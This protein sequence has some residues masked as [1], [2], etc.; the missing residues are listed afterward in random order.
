[1]CES[2]PLGAGH[3]EAEYGTYDSVRPRAVWQEAVS[4]GCGPDSQEQGPGSGV[5]T[6]IWGQCFNHNQD[7]ET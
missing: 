7:Q 6:A 5:G 4:Q 2:T 1:M 3:T